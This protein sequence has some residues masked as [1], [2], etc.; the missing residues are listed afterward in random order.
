MAAHA[1]TEDHDP[2]RVASS[3]KVVLETWKHLIMASTTEAHRR[4]EM[5]ESAVGGRI[6]WPYLSYF[7]AL[8]IFAL[9]AFVPYFF[10]WTGVALVFIGNYFFGSCGVNIGYHR[11]LTH[12]SFKCSKWLE[13]TFAILGICSLQDSP[14]RWVA[15]HR[16]HHQ[17]SDERPDPHS[18][19]VSFLWGHMGW[20][21]KENREVGTLAMFDRY[22]RDLISDRFYRNLHRNFNWLGVWFLH[23]VLFAAIG[24]LVAYMVSPTPEKALQ[25][26]LSIFV[27]GVIVRTVYVWHITWAVNSASH[28]W[29]YR[30]YKTGEDSTNNWVV[31]LL[32]NGEGWHN[33][34]HADQR[35]AAHGHKWW[36]MDL[37]YSTIK[38][39]E[40]LGLVW[41]VLPPRVP[42]HRRRVVGTVTNVSEE[43]TESIGT[44]EA[45]VEGPKRK[46]V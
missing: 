45:Q 33:N 21:V 26:G 30:N 43:D 46:A 42:K 36:E 5:P 6:F 18:P 38:L 8:H 16:M 13:R 39:L 12:G 44:P 24:F 23:V 14:V 37:T 40:K 2:P 34:H 41:D 25:F 27:W 28:L 22:A 35:S 19:L 32:T 1:V 11:L 9:L 20:L 29:G 4:L 10:S 31:A 17:Y 7:I 3:L 15:V